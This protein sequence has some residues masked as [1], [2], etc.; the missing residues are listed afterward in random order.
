MEPDSLKQF[1]DEGWRVKYASSDAVHI[2]KPESGSFRAHV[3]VAV[4][5][6]WWTLGLGNLVY[7]AYKFHTE[8]ESRVITGCV[9]EISD[10]DE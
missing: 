1:R 8:S 9:D 7:G 6:A 2:I 10:L 4:L 5:T 3:V